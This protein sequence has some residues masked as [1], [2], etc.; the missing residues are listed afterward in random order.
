MQVKSSQQIVEWSAVDGGS[1]Q[2]IRSAFGKTRGSPVLSPL[3]RLLP[4]P[5]PTAL[6]VH[7]VVDLIDSG[8]GDWDGDKIE[9]MFWPI[10]RDIILSIPISRT[11]DED[12][13][14]W[15]FSNNGIF[16]VRSAYHLSCDLNDEASGSNLKAEQTWWK[17][18][19]QAKLP[20]PPSGFVKLNFD[21]AILD[22]GTAI[23]IGVVARDERGR[24]IGWLSRRIDVMVSGEMAEAWAAREATQ[25]ALRRGWLMVVIEGDCL[26]LI[27]KIRNATQDFSPVGPVI[28]DIHKSASALSSCNLTLLNVPVIQLLTVWLNLLMW[29]LWKEMIF[30]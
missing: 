4:P 12:I 9:A 17:S 23:G 27:S 29:H 15:H 28:S 22:K 6:E 1:V 30:H 14:I 20:G 25:L 8:Y 13:I 10:G 26:V 18:I 2:G 24:C 21:G 16:S 3:N 11:G 19:W 7:T 5:P